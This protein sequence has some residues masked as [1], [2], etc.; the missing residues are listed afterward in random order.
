MRNFNNDITDCI[1]GAKGSGKSVFLAYLL[2]TS[3]KRS[4]L[5]DMLGVFNPRNRYKTAVIPNSYYCL[6]PDDFINN[7]D[8]FPKNAKVVIDFSGVYSDE[9]IDK[10]DEISKLLM[11]VGDWEV[12]SDEIA[13]FMPLH[14]GSR[15]FHQLVKNGRNFGIK[16]IIFATQRPQSVNKNIFDLCDCFLVS[17]QKAPRTIDYIMDILDKK[18][19]NETGSIIRKLEQREFL[20]Y[21]GNL[22]KFKVPFYKH[23]FKQ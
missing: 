1:L 6:T 3:K 21:D 15:E 18:G 5:F 7:I 4:V 17:Q 11:S 14:S 13:D 22:S 9:L 2:F 23:S 8:K 20:I 10:I 19:D 12:L 16:P